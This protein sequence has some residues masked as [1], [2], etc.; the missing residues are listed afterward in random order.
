MNAGALSLELD[1]GS[2]IGSIELSANAGSFEVCAPD[3]IGLEITVG[4]NVAT[5]HNL[6]EAGLTEDGDVWRTLGFDS[7]DTQIEISFSG[8][9]ASFNLNPDGGC[10]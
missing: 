9:A 5:G 4:E 1:A 10:S 6:E 3:D 8:N 7:A 2:Q